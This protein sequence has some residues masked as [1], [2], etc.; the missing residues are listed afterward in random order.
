[1]LMLSPTLTCTQVSGDALLEF[2]RDGVEYAALGI[3]ATALLAALAG[4]VWPVAR[5]RF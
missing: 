5:A 2:Q 4:M 1:M 3:S